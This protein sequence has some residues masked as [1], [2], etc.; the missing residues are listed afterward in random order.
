MLTTM[1]QTQGKDVVCEK[2]VD[3][4]VNNEIYHLDQ[5]HSIFLT[6]QVLLNLFYAYI[7]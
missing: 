6:F 1:A 3:I 7:N 5:H 2:N 4:D